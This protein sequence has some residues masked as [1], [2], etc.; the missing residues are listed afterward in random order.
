[1]GCAPM[2]PP[3][4]TSIRCPTIAGPFGHMTT[5]FCIGDSSPRTDEPGN[6]LRGQVPVRVL[7]EDLSEEEVVPDPH[8][9]KDDDGCHRG[10]RHRQ[11][12]FVENLEVRSA[13]DARRLLDL[14]REGPEKVPHEEDDPRDPPSGMD[15]DEAE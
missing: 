1:M 12:D 11:N 8:E 7:D 14:K 4:R 10:Q 5:G 13:V 6:T 15:E 3:S 2:P 9:L